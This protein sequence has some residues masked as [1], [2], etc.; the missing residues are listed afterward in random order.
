[1]DPN[2]ENVFSSQGIQVLDIEGQTYVAVPEAWMFQDELGIAA[3]EGEAKKVPP[4]QNPALEMPGFVLIDMDTFFE[5]GVGLGAIDGVTQS[6]DGSFLIDTELFALSMQ[7]QLHEIAISI[8][9]K[10]IEQIE[11][12]GKRIKEKNA[13]EEI[14]DQRQA[15]EFR[16]ELID[17][18]VEKTPD[19]MVSGVN[20]DATISGIDAFKMK[21]RLKAG[22]VEAMDNYIK[23]GD[24]AQAGFILGALVIGGTFVA[25]FAAMAV[26]GAVPASTPGVHIA[27]HTVSELAPASFMQSAANLGFMTVNLMVGTNMAVNAERVAGKKGAGKKPDLDMAKAYGEKTLRMMNDKN[28]N[29]LL[30][31]AANGDE[32]L[33]AMSKFVQLSLPLVMNYRLEAGKITGEEF[34]ALLRG[35]IEGIEEGDIKLKLVAALQGELAKIDPKVAEELLLNLIAYYESDTPVEEL[36]DPSKVMKKIRQEKKN[37]MLAA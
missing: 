36:L 27:L 26:T 9:D 32:E 20:A 21:E 25:D 28:A 34:A 23:T 37:N 10:W 1:M 18:K 8:L 31:A 17:Q 6:E 2:L 4:S 11:E 12:D 5:T 7:N 16:K 33:I 19:F 15:Q 29:L 30:K 24:I 13:Q 3:V 22:Q 35:E 14:M